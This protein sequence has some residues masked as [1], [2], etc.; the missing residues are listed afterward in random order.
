M[1][2]PDAGFKQLPCGGFHGLF[3]KVHKADFQVVMRKGKP[4]VFD[5]AAEAEVAGW[6]ALRDHLCREIVA[7]RTS[8]DWKKARAKLPSFMVQTKGSRRQRAA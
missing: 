1:N 4:R 5:S 2:H 3:R 7:D 8:I 6:R